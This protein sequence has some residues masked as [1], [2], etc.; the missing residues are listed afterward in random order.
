MSRTKAMVL[1][2]GIGGLTTAV[3]LERVGIDV[4]VYEASPEQRRTGTG[5][6]IAA[7]ATAV[8]T[9]LG[10]DITAVGQPVRAFELL[11]PSGGPLRALPF[12]Q[13]TEEL[14]AP[15]VSIHR[16]ELID[17]LRG[18]S[19]AAVQY[20]ARATGY[21]VLPGGGVE[22][23]FA[24]GRTAEA[25][26]LI[27]ADGIRST[28]RAALHGEQPVTEHGYVCWLA[29]VDFAHERM[30]PG[31]CGHYWG[32][33]QRFGLIDIGGGRAY[34][35]GTKN[36]PAEHARNWNGGKAAILTA[37]DGWAPELR[38]AVEATPEETIVSVPAQDRPFSAHWGEG[39]VT[40][41]GDAAHPMLTSLS[42]GAGASV[43]DAYVLAQHLGER[44]LGDGDLVAGLRDYERARIPRTKELVSGSRRL[45]RTEQWSNPLAC[46]ARDAVLRHL[47]MPMVRKINA[48]PMRFAITP[49]PGATTGS[50]R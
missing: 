20:G 50:N 48:D 47:P 43:E 11:T 22:V 31:W 45:S 12:A 15:I 3:A 34:W 28:I 24:D 16:N 5:L 33:G 6:G 4:T 19:A 8:L 26:V 10:V 39:P 25:D 9:A 17:T 35:W 49:L 38:A 18:A 1:G 29:V 23:A 27:G 41:L 46:L 32:R 36:M 13:I 2:A 14:G 21:R 42:Q 44:L 37:F 30:T 40:L 7:N